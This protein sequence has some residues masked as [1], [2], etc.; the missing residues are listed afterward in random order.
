MTA[1]QLQ[2]LITQID[3]AILHILAGG[4]EYEITSS[5]AGGSK[6]V[7]KGADIGTL[8]KMKAEYESQLASLTNNRAVKI[9]AGW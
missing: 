4:Q 1:I 9:R 6:R 8:N 5:M 7:F 3:A 2:A